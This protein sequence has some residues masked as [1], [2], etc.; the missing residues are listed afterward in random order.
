MG[1]KLSGRIPWIFL[2]FGLA[3]GFPSDSPSEVEPRGFSS[4]SAPEDVSP[5]TWFMPLKDKTVNFPVPPKSG[6]S[7]SG[8]TSSRV[9][10]TGGSTGSKFFSAG[11]AGSG[12]FSAG[13]GG[14]SGVFSAGGGAGSG[15]LV[16]AGGG[17]SGT[18]S[19]LG[20]FQELLGLGRNLMSIRPL[21]LGQAWSNNLHVAFGSVAK[22]PRYPSSYVILSN[23]AYQRERDGR[24]NS[25]Y[26]KDTSGHVPLS[27]S[28]SGQMGG[29]GSKGHQVQ[30]G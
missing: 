25:K 28:H 29:T 20:V 9:F 18:F 4:E 27:E 17:G 21:S 30:R 5:R 22:R 12:V 14:G 26:I 1:L 19:A 8:G 11:G 6:I 10:A 23:S 15:V 7:S 13:G 24:T 3:A 16:S 2:L